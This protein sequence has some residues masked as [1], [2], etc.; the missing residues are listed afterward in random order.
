M[1]IRDPNIYKKARLAT[2]FSQEQA[3]ERLHLSVES[4]K[5][6]ETGQRIPPNETVARMA[7]VYGAEWLKLM[8]MRETTAP[9]EILPEQVRALP[10]PVAVL[11][12]VS[13][14]YRFA[15]ANAAQNLVTIA[16]DGVIAEDEREEFDRIVSELDG[17]VA[18]ALSLKCCIG[19]KKDRPETAISKRPRF[20]GNRE[21]HCKNIISQSRGNASKICAREGA[22]SP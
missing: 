15:E 16:E 13:R 9:L 20:R 22:T 7:E 10:L 12:L 4:V 8:H 14:A 2:P 3:A 1:Q 11:Q 18:A 21:N 19:A 5:A 17:I 6:Y